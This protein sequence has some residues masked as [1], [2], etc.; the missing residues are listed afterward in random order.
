MAYLLHSK[1]VAKRGGAQC[2]K[3][4]EDR[5]KLPNFVRYTE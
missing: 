3:L 2:R 4:D 5:T 1:K